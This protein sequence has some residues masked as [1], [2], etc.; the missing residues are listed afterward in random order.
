MLIS[1]VWAIP[2]FYGM[3]SMTNWNCTA[4]CTCTLTYRNPAHHICQVNDN[5]TR[6]TCST[7]YTPM[8]KSYLFV[9]SIIWLL[10][11]FVL[12]ALFVKSLLKVSRSDR[13]QLNA[14]QTTKLNS[15]I[16]SDNTEKKINNLPA[17]RKFR[18]T[19]IISK[20]RSSHQVLLA[21]FSLFFVCTAPIMTCFGIDYLSASNVYFNSILVNVLTPLPFIYCLFSPLLLLRK[22]GG[23]RNATSML[24]TLMLTPRR[25]NISRKK[26]GKKHEDDIKHNDSDRNN[27]SLIQN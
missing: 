10:E 20:Y 25:L 1:V 27:Q 9:V 19:R 14:V 13:S 8:A 23:L 2:T 16:S 7:I 22:L 11:C 12:V 4:L 26:K 24:L 17:K 6:S 21:L 5:S 18:A 3:L 15:L